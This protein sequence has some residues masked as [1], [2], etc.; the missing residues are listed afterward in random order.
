M[1][2]K[3]PR[4]TMRYAPGESSSVN[5]PW[6]GHKQQGR[7]YY[8]EGD[9]GEAL[10]SYRA[11]LNPDFRC[12]AVDAQIIRSNICTCRLKIGGSAQADA[13]VQDAKQCVEMN[14]SW[15]KGHV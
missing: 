13:A 7:E 1:T 4:V 11:T 10:T 6:Q 5:T 12:P 14:P 8:E 15:A 3:T 9:Y 2:Q